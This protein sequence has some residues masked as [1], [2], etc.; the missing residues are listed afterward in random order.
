MKDLIVRMDKIFNVRVTPGAKKEEIVVDDNNIIAKVKA[1]PIDGKANERL[2]ELLSEFFD[3]PKSRVKILKGLNKK[4]K[5]VLIK[6]C[7]E[8]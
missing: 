8:K 2:I 6:D 5:L 4:N 3:M 1:E 7:D